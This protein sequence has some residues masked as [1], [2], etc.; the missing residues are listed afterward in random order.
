[1]PVSTRQ[2]RSE[3]LLA[4]LRAGEILPREEAELTVRLAV[5]AILAQIAVILMQY[6]DA[7]MVGQ[8]GARES[9]AVGLV[10]SSIWLFFGFTGASVMGFSVQAA[11]RIGAGDSTRAKEIVCEG[12]T[13]VFWFS[14]AIAMIGIVIAPYLP[15]W[16]G[17]DPSIHV[18]SAAYFRIRLIFLPV[19]LLGWLWGSFLRVAGDMKTPSV[20]GVVMCMLDVVF[21]FFLIYPSRT[22]YWLGVSFEMPGASMGVEG[23]AWG[24][25]AAEVIVAVATLWFLA[26]KSPVLAHFAGEGNFRP[27]VLT[28]K[29]ALRLALP[30][31]AERVLMCGAQIASTAIVAPL[32]VAAVAAHSLAITAESLC[33][34]PGY[35]VSEAATTLVG[36]SIGAGRRDVARRI[37]F[38]CVAGGMLVMTFMGAVLWFAAPVLIGWMT[39]VSEVID[40]AT[41]VLR[42]EAWAEPMFAAAIVSYGVFV[43]AG[44]TLV[45]ASMNLASMWFVRLTL[46]LV[47]APSYGLAGVWTAM[48]IELCVRGSVFLLRLRYGKWAKGAV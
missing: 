2:K 8:L 44:D 1:M 25:A 17:G 42:I 47:L 22:V 12:T 6:I 33:Y 21:N 7:A 34:M 40:L 4:R 39:S 30:V 10:S 23:A 32:G 37:A 9:A 15:G 31:G 11:H 36:Q 28:L 13:T 5:P 20:L 48:C 18:E 38:K 29:K 26:R 3:E 16:L 14:T 43:G 41:T 45:P 19:M 46:A 35:G 24:S 27:K